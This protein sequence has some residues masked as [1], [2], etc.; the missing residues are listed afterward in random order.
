MAPRKNA[1][2]NLALALQKAS[3]LNMLRC[4]LQIASNTTMLL[5]CIKLLSLA[6]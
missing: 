5:H 4:Y 6:V 1:A 3:R 2:Q